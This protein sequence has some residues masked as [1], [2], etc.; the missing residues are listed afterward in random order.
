M[1]ECAA[2]AV[3][4]VTAASFSVSQIPVHGA[5]CLL[6]GIIAYEMIFSDFTCRFA[7]DEFVSIYLSFQRTTT[8]L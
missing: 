3:V 5:L 8:T 2:S 7:D 6:A 4:I 1:A